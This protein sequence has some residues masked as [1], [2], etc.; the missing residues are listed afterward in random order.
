[1]L[2]GF[3][4]ECISLFRIACKV[5]AVPSSLH[6]RSAAERLLDKVVQ[7]AHRVSRVANKFARKQIYMHVCG[8]AYMRFRDIALLFASAYLHIARRVTVDLDRSSRTRCMISYL[9]NSIRS[10]PPPSHPTTLDW[11]A[12][13]RAPGYGGA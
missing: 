7:T 9:I 1:M 6:E 8:L 13:Y 4:A 5:P 2:M 11:A 12:A 10:K 3:F